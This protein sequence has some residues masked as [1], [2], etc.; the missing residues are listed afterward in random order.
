M[1]ETRTFTE[2]HIKRQRRSH[3]EAD[4]Y[5][6]HRHLYLQNPMVELATEIA[7]QQGRTPAW[8]DYGCGKGGF[9]E[10]IRKLGVFGEIVGWDP[11]VDAFKVKP[12]GKF[13]IVTCLDVLDAIEPNFTEAVIVDVA[14]ATAGVAIFDVLTRPKATSKLKPHPPFYWTHIVG[15]A[16]RVLKSRVEFPG[17][18]SF[19]RVV[20]FAEPKG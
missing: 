16:M 12:E 20:I 1:D 10:E 15:R 7:R 6:R 5:G 2:A 3:A 17:M 9:I 19:E 14:R 11:A 4:G 18:D 13:D 8:L